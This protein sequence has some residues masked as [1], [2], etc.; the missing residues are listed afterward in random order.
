MT[1]G[2]EDDQIAA[3][4]GYPRHARCMDTGSQVRLLPAS[5]NHGEVKDL[6]G[7]ILR[8]VVFYFKAGSS[9]LFSL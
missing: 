3:E 9:G 2:K 7:H 6:R 8:E 4:Q 5:K 1:K